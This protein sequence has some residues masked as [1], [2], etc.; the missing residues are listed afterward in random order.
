MKAVILFVALGLF[1]FSSHAQTEMSFL[2]V[3][4]EPLIDFGMGKY[5]IGE[6]S[7]LLDEGSFNP[8]SLGGRLGLKLGP[9][10][11]GF[12][13][14]ES[15]LIGGSSDMQVSASDRE[16]YPR[17]N[18]ATLTSVGPSLGVQVGRVY[19]WGAVTAESLEQ[20]LLKPE[21]YEHEY[22]G[23]GVRIS[24]DFDVFKNIHAGFFYHSRSF[25]KYTSTLSTDTVENAKLP[26]ELNS[27]TYGIKL[28]YFFSISQMPGL[29]KT[30][31]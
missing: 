1:S 14:Y 18:D 5:E 13:Y 8:L 28:S 16:R 31:K 12:D 10:F 17:V 26:N 23:T 27:T 20:D 22:E 7:N 24:L 25:D 11:V 6:S 29:S 21:K 9:V 30:F 2:D 19:L 15:G 3:Y 4:V